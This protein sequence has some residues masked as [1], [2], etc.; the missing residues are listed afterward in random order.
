MVIPLTGIEAV[1]AAAEHASK[2]PAGR[3]GG[4][5][6]PGIGLALCDRV[7]HFRQK[8]VAAIVRKSQGDTLER[9]QTAGIGSLLPQSLV[10]QLWMAD[11][12]EI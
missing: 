1:A 3:V 2:A 10:P 5:L 11:R 12:S 6:A 4:F 7:A 9:T 8:N